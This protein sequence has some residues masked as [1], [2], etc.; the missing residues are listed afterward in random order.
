MVE[1]ISPPESP[2][3]GYRRHWGWDGT[4]FPRSLPRLKC[5][6]H[7]HSPPGAAMSAPWSLYQTL[8]G[9]DEELD[10]GDDS[11]VVQQLLDRA[12]LCKSRVVSRWKI[13]RTALRYLDMTCGLRRAA[14][15]CCR[16]VRLQQQ[17]NVMA[18]LLTAALQLRHYD[19]N[20][21]ELW[22]RSAQVPVQN[23][24]VFLSPRLSLLI[25]TPLFLVQEHNWER[26]RQKLTLIQKSELPAVVSGS[27]VGFQLGPGTEH[28][29]S[30]PAVVDHI[31]LWRART[32]SEV[33]A[34]AAP[35]ETASCKISSIDSADD[36]R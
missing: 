4:T 9:F 35:A 11:Q 29:V 15:W 21:P 20:P 24:L 7:M 12:M 17:G 6:T 5:D 19:W 16:S 30:L 28:D 23:T 34:A 25:L 2:K 8:N 18:C 27:T 13:S 1:G 36:S 33:V 32:G 31:A 26:W 22:S 10:D 3:T 14:V